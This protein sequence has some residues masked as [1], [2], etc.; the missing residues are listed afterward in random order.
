MNWL[1]YLVEA[2]IYLSVFYLFYCLLLAKETHYMLNRIY[3]LGSCV[4]S[5]ILPVVQ[6]GLLRPADTLINHTIIM[7]TAPENFVLEAVVLIVY[8]LVASVFIA[9]LLIKLYR[10]QRLTSEGPVISNNDY[11]LIYLKDSNTAFSFF[12]YLFIGTEAPGVEIITHHEMVHIRQKHSV[13]IIFLELI[14]IMSWFNPVVYLL[15][16]SLKTVHEYIADEQTAAYETDTLTYSTFLVNNAYGIS[17]SLVTNSFFNYNLLKKRIM[18][19]HQQPSGN[20]ARLKYFVAVPVC[21]ALLCV[22]TLSFSKTYGWVDIAPQQ[23]VPPP[24]P[25][26]PPVH[27]KEHKAPPPPPEP[28]ASVKDHKAPPPPPE[29]PVSQSKNTD[30]AGRP[31]P[32]KRKVNAVKFPPPVIIP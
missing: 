3:L 14:K 28:P 11:K 26:A 1:H 19:L 21:A 22:S 15:Q 23:Q 6:L 2:N 12:N 13:D 32:P 8:L 30:K 7:T 16:I 25:P 5:F 31:T 18:K 9:L 4:L 10:L 17:G 20:L 24:P 27:A 29:P